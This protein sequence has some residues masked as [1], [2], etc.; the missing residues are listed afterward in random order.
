MLSR[1]LPVLVALVIGALVVGAVALLWP[2]R[3]APQ[4]EIVGSADARTALAELSRALQTGDAGL[5]RDLGTE[6]TSEQLAVAA[7]NTRRIGVQRISLRPGQ[8]RAEPDGGLLVDARLQWRPTDGRPIRSSLQVTLVEQDGQP[9]IAALTGTRLPL[10]LIGPI[11]SARS[12]GVLVVASGADQRQADRLLPVAAAA[13]R[14]VRGVLPADGRAPLLLVQLPADEQALEEHLDVRT[15]DYRGI[16]A[17]TA[18]AGERGAATVLLNPAEYDRLDRLG[19]RVVL[20]HEATHVVTG[21]TGR[22]APA[23]L[24][25]GFADYVALRDVRVPARQ[26][27]R[28]LLARPLPGRLPDETDFQRR[29]AALA[30][31]YE[32]AWLACVEIADR[33]GEQ[34]LVGLERA[35]ERGQPWRQA[36]HRRTGLTPQ[37]LTAHWRDRVAAL[38]G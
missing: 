32:G 27:A 36:L 15:G 13:D 4:P 11:R 33:R 30:A 29:G 21:V 37:R 5:A 26:S 9:R 25:E 16:A 14:S 18:P 12:D 8:L 3:S 1:R 17:V 23:W 35:V 22:R 38:A 19:R 2:S 6:A 10:W 24:R 7:A 20:T 34:A 31:A 28:H